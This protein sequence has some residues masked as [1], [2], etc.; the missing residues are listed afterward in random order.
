MRKRVFFH[1]ALWVT[2][3]VYNLIRGNFTGDIFGDALI[4]ELSLIFMVYLVVCSGPRAAGIFAL[5][6]GFL[7]DLLSGGGRGLFLGFHLIA[8]CVTVSGRNLFDIHHPKGQLI[9]T[10]L[11]VASGKL[12]FLATVIFMSPNA[13][14]TWPW[15]FRAAS[16][17]IVSGIVAPLIIVLLQSI[18]R[19]YA[20]DWTEGFE[21]QLDE[22]GVL[23]R[24]WGHRNKE[25]QS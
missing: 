23:P 16:A 18:R 11:S 21:A 17:A 1:A 6:Q 12:L 5:C 10:V 4:P 3:T 20:P 2:A 22:V 15:V 14:F 19:Q 9:I 8:F 24:L 25:N 7:M 13:F